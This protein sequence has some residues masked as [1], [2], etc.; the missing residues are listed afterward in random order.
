[1]ERIKEYLNGK[2]SV[3]GATG[4]LIITLT[5]SNILGMLRDHFLAQ[6]IPADLLDTYYVAF[7]LP[8]LIF[9]I[10]ILG[11]IAAAFIPVFTNYI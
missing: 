3:K 2:N 10:L 11:A 7:R 9:N 6:K 5:F 8:D 4:I 1:M